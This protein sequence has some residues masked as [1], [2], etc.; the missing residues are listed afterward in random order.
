MVDPDVP[1][2]D[3]AAGTGIR[4]NFLHWYVSGA[5]S[6]CATSQS[7]ETVA[8]YQPPTPGSATEH[9]YTFLVYREPAGY[10]P[11]IIS[12]NLRLGFDVNTYAADGGLELVGGN[13]FLEGLLS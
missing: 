4:L 1:S 8:L 12:P 11:L 6:I 7:P 9:R 2:P 10:E 5:K 3:G 13:F